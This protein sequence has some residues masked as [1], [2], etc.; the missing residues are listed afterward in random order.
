[1]LH[2]SLTTQASA[3]KVV[4]QQS[5]RGLTEGNCYQIRCIIA[6]H[7][8]TK[9]REPINFLPEAQKYEK[10]QAS[11]GRVAFRQ[12]KGL[13]Q[14]GHFWP[15]GSKLYLY[16]TRTHFDLQATQQM[17]SNLTNQTLVK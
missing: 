10:I 15:A 17:R 5:S 3:R 12:D 6:E 14:P 8:F 2:R 1:M 9:P 16:S 13:N 7:G 11:W 4:S